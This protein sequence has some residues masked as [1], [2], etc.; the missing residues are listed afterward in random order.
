[1]DRVGE[2]Y[3]AVRAA[4]GDQIEITIIDPRNLISFLPLVIRDAFRNRVPIGSALRAISSTSL[5]T[6]VFDGELLYS[7]SIPPPAEVV[8][9]IAGRMAVHKVGSA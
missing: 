8:E 9:V 7:R 4:F 2:I 6:G 3:R 1:M 5:S